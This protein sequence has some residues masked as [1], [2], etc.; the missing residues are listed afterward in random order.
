[1]G[2]KGI[3]K[4]PEKSDM[5]KVVI[6]NVWGPT[7]RGDAALVEALVA[8]IHKMLRD[9]PH[10]ISGLATHWQLQSQQI[11]DV[12]WHGALIYSRFQDKIPRRVERLLRTAAIVPY[13]LLG[14]SPLT[15]LFLSARQKKACDLLKSADL[16]MTAPGGFIL[17]AHLNVISMLLEIMIPKMHGKKVFLSP[18]SIG[19][20]RSGILKYIVS[21]ALD[22]CDTI[23][24]R[25]P[26]SMEFVQQELKVPRSRVIRMSDL[27]FFHNAS[28]RQ[29]AKRILEEEF[30]I[31]PGERFIAATVVQW[32]F[33]HH[34]DPAALRRR[35]L[36]AVGDALS[37]AGD[38]YDAK[39]VMLN[40][41]SEDL[42]NARIVKEIVGKR[43]LIDT[44]DRTPAV[45]RGMFFHATL[46]VTSRFHSCIFSLLE[47]TPS[48]AI[49][50]V[51]KTEG[52]MRELKLSDWVHSIETVGASTILQQID[53]IM[54]RRDQMSISVQEKVAA[55]RTKFPNYADLIGEALVGNAR[56]V[57]GSSGGSESSA[58][59][60]RARS[61]QV[62]AT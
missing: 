41:V 6:T 50:Y 31:R 45:M 25:E 48:I 30:G 35:Y 13:L 21:K 43:L 24:L 54:A 29:L 34:R 4:H 1:M 20:V 60:I 17:D 58:G 14:D 16:V 38:R 3:A 11:P 12:E 26:I 61:T 42:P 15:R 53:E 19:P 23:C 44:K 36:Q 27:A 62:P 51:W 37:Q 2:C 46:S 49:S 47:G 18:Q 5:K 39:I 56:P 9:I 8:E 10:R 28:E 33:P 32:N 22:G 59:S 7:N 55:Y 52:I 40:Q 57:V